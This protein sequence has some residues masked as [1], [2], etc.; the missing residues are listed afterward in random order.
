MQVSNNSSPSFSGIHIKSSAMN[1]VQQVL[2]R[3]ISDML[4]YSDEYVKVADQ[5]DVYF[6]PGKSEKSVVV[7]FLDSFS[8]MFFRNGK[9]PVKVSINNERSN[10]AKSVDE[11]RG[12][13]LDIDTGKID[14]PIYDERRFLDGTT[15][16]V[17][18]D[19]DVYAELSDDVIEL[20]PTIG[21][22]AAESLAIDIYQRAKKLI[23]T[24]EF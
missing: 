19:P 2:S 5:V 10:F 9:D 20:Q 6:L 24:D 15:D 13:L 16:L 7:K 18:L 14:S 17:K 1:D 3:R 11:I 8:D 23:N 21:R 12:K 22:D 4:D